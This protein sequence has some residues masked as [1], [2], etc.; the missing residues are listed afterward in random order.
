MCAVD[1]LHDHEVDVVDAVEVDDAHDVGVTQGRDRA[2]LL[3]E[4][5]EQ[6]GVGRHVRVQHLDRHGLLET[7][8]RGP[9]DRGHAAA[10]D[11]RGDL[12]AA[13][14]AADE[15]RLPCSLRRASGQ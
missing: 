2:R 9:V 13:Q 14:R 7:G 5:A 3:L 8:V 15:T 6:V 11:E 4:P 1:V 12:V 10:A